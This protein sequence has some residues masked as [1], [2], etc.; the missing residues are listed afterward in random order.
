MDILYVTGLTDSK[1][2]NMP[3]CASKVLGKFDN[4]HLPDPIE[5]QRI[6]GSL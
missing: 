5:Y 4:V 3:I 2:V 6:L 1:T